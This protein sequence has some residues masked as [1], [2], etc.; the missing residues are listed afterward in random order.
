[1]LTAVA[2]NISHFVEWR[3]CLQIMDL[4]TIH[5]KVILFSIK[6]LSNWNE[7][8]F[9]SGN[10]LAYVGNCSLNPK[11][12]KVLPA[13]Q[14]Q[15]YVYSKESASQPIGDAGK[16]IWRH[17]C[18]PNPRLKG[19]RWP[20]LISYACAMD[21]PCVSP[22]SSPL[23][24]CNKR[25]VLRERGVSHSWE[26]APGDLFKQCSSLHAV[27]WTYWLHYLDQVKHL[28]KWLYKNPLQRSH[29][30]MTSEW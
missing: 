16:K 17:L 4:K 10:I 20:Q 30:K 14:P 21:S 1:M 6:W 26:L 24:W 3:F 15:E 29:R 11:L 22:W 28:D 23:T 5:F 25:D 13:P 18:M 19:R 7:Q 9:L 8:V 27:T 12:L 2:E